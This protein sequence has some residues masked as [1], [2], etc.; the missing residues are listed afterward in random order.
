MIHGKKV[1][2]KIKL[3]DHFG[4]GRLLRFTLLSIAMMIFTSIYGVVD[5]FFVSNFVGKTPFAAVSFIFPFLMILGSVGF[6]FGTG[7]SALVS[8]TLGERDPEKANR[9]FSLLVYVSLALGIVIA[10][11]GIVFLR[12]IASLLGAEDQML[13]DCVLYGRVILIALPAY[14]LQLE[15]QSFFVTAE[16]PKMGLWITVMSGLTNMVLDFL[17]VGVFPL[18]LVGA[19]VATG[20]S[21]II[22][23]IVPLIYFARKNTSL[24]RLTKTDFDKKALVKTCTNGSSELLGNISMSLVSMLYNVQLLKVAGENGVAAY[25]VIMYVN[26]VFLSAFIG[27][28]IG[29]SPVVG[30]HYGAQNHGELKSIVR[31][32]AVLIGIGSLAMFCLGIALARP[33]SS[34]FVSYDPELLEITVHGFYIFAVSFLPVGYAIFLPGFFTALSDGL[35]SAIISFTRTMIFQVAAVLLLPLA[36]GIDGIWWSVVVAEGLSVVVGSI[37]L[38]AKRNK[39]HY[40]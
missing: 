11:L 25:G 15:F 35:V 2:E 10:V 20:M 22:G 40:L 4:Y 39:Y 32:S 8:K 36:F 12:P 28:S 34:I 24:L 17:L 16:K 7:G 26:F 33:L 9:I 3:S 1:K 21:Q 30:F 5:G 38:Y 27:Y 19:A 14:I 18:G 23:G 37:F 31:I 13:D 29:T 6:M